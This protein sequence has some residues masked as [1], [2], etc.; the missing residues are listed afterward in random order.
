MLKKSKVIKLFGGNWDFYRNFYVTL[1]IKRNHATELVT[2][3]LAV[4]VT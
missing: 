1:K 2:K 4:T 3:M